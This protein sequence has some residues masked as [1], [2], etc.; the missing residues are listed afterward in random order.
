M[1]LSVI[2]T[3][4]RLENQP[5]SKHKTMKLALPVKLTAFTTIALTSLIFSDRPVNAT[6]YG[7]LEVE[8]TQFIAVAVPFGNRQYNFMVLEQIAGKQQCWSESGSKP[9]TIDPLLLNFDFSGSCRRAADSNG[10]SIRMN[11]QDYGLDYLLSVVERD[12]E[13]L[14]IGTPRGGDSNLSEVLVGRSY[15]IAEGLSK[16]FLNPSWRFTKRTFEA[17]TLGHIYLTN[18]SIVTN[19]SET[20]T[21]NTI[22]N[23]TITAKEITYA[24]PHTNSPNLLP[25]PTEFSSPQPGSKSPTIVLDDSVNNTKM[26]NDA[27]SYVDKLLVPDIPI[28]V[29]TPDNSSNISVTSQLPTKSYRVIVKVSNDSQAS[30]VRS[31]YPQAFQTVYQG[32]SILQIGRFS[33]RQNAETTLQNVENLGWDGIIIDN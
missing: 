33:S 8:Q 28:P 25:T 2:F 5:T 12:G 20:S 21:A 10:Y 22:V 24:A 9:V 11:G 6:D 16:I 31:L 26:N 7:E 27:D 4:L 15:G 30:Q 19:H 23:E 32:K 17:K 3:R 1:Q 13:L 14:L 18:D 29:S